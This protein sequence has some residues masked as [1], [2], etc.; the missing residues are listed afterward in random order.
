MG[1]AMA[2]ELL[3]EEFKTAN[4]NNDLMDLMNYPSD[5]RKKGDCPVNPPKNSSKIMCFKVCG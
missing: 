3:E 1:Q 4:I 2:V 5:I